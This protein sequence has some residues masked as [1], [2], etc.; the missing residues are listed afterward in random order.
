MRWFSLSEDR[1]IKL[2]FKSKNVSEQRSVMVKHQLILMRLKNIVLLLK[3]KM[4][5]QIIKKSMIKVEKKM[6][7]SVLKIF[8][9]GDINFRE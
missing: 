1:Q 4:N 2:S 5:L 3:F 6:R 8:A 9:G 7:K